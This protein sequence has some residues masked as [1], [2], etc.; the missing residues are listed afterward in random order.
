MCM[1]TIF[2]PKIM[3]NHLSENNNLVIYFNIDNEIYFCFPL[4]SEAMSLEG[5]E[6]ELSKE[7]VQPLRKGRSMSTL[8][9]ALAQEESA[10]NTTLQ[11]QK[12]CVGHLE[13]NLSLFIPSCRRKCV[14]IHAQWHKEYSLKIGSTRIFSSHVFS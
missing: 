6:W 13:L 9:C 2:N 10:R 3:N 11:Q 4:H 7:N 14:W 8:Q 5:D 12:R 1:P